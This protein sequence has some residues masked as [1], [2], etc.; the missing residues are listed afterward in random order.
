RTARLYRDG[1]PDGAGTY[2]NA[3]PIVIGPGR[4]GMW[5]DEPRSF[6]GS[7]D[8]LRIYDRALGDDEIRALA[9]M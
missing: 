4:I 6:H 8:D 7:M 1:L 9:G 5:D 3:R 2:T